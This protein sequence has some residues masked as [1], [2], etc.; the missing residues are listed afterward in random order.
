M[1]SLRLDTEQRFTCASCARCCTRPWEIVVTP[2]EAAS[3]R[4]RNTAR[5]FRDAAGGREGTDRD[6]FEPIPGTQGFHRIRKRDG[7]ACGFLSA[8]NRCRLHEELGAR[9]KP[10]TCRLFPFSFHA[11]ADAVAVTTSF[12]CPTIVANEGEPIST[13]GSLESVKGLSGEWF[14]TYPA[15]PAH[16]QYVSGRRMDASTL[17]VLRTS[18][19]QMLTRAD[20]AGGIDLRTNVVR[21]AQALEDLAR[22]AVVRLKDDEFAEYVAI[23]T[24]FA[25]RSDKPVVTRGPSWNGRLMQRGFLFLIAATQLQVEHRRVS[26]ST[27]MLRL[28]AFKL[29]AHFHGM[30]RGVG[31]FDL[32]LLPVRAVDANA[33]DLQPLVQHYLRSSIQT[34]GTG[35]R[36]VLDELAVAVSSLNAAC[37]LARMRASQAGGTVNRQVFSEALVDAVD[38]THADYGSMARFLTMFAGGIEALYAFGNRANP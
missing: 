17:K 22:P 26:G 31:A 38:V 37:V 8:A 34:L 23:T 14:K 20:A 29:L 13:G 6:P 35:A 19:L 7:G 18:L 4:Q 16:L 3:Y 12:A 10:L 15:S 2:A 11:V 21:M 24:P 25:A 1:S 36:P 30:A 32:R 27:M 28:E 33:P 9:M 5:W